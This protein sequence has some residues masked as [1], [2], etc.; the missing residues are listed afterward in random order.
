MNCHQLQCCGYFNASDLVQFGG[1]FC[2][3][4]TFVNSLNTTV[5]SNFCVTPITHHVD[6]SLNNVFSYV[7]PLFPSRH[8][9]IQDL[10]LGRHMVLWPASSACFSR[11]YASSKLCVHYRPLEFSHQGSDYPRRDKR[12]NGSGGSMQNVGEGDLF[13][14]DTNHSYPL[15][16]YCLVP[17]LAI[18]TS[19]LHCWRSSKSSRYGV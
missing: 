14:M 5:T 1:S 8:N 12:S 15:P 7:E 10:L 3:N 19:L 6:V 11:R 4:S 18:S 16:S 2:Q 9:D 13:E 17:T